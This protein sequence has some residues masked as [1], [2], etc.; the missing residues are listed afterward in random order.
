MNRQGLHW[1]WSWPALLQPANGALA[2]G[3]STTRASPCE[4]SMAAPELAGLGW[5]PGPRAPPPRNPAFLLHGGDGGGGPPSSLAPMAHLSTKLPV[6]LAA[7]A[8]RASSAAARD[9]EP[10]P[11]VQGRPLAADGE[12][13]A[14]TGWPVA[15]AAAAAGATQPRTSATSARTPA[16]RDSASP[17][18]GARTMALLLTASSFKPPQVAPSFKWTISSSGA[19]WSGDDGAM[20]AKYGD[21]P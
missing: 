11:G 2:G 12:G 21:G 15:K 17:T 14:A 20:A 5:P 8:A 4:G 18:V 3:G 19:S 16:G 13:A 7:G 6:G 10:T 9:P 1:P